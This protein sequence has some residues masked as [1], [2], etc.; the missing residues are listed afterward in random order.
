MHRPCVGSAGSLVYLAEPPGTSGAYFLL[1]TAEY[2]LRRTH[3]SIVLGEG[4]REVVENAAEPQASVLYTAERI[5]TARQLADR[6]IPVAALPLR[7]VW[8]A[9]GAL[10][11][12]V[13]TRAK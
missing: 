4:R 1:I 5:P 12:A 3:E 9:E 11:G 8:D 13:L 10:A 6:Q 7:G 2:G